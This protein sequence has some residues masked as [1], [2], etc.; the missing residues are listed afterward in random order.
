MDQK[1]QKIV[2]ATVSEKIIIFFDGYCI[3]C[4]K[5]VDFLISKD[6]K[7][8]FLFATLQSKTATNILNEIGFQEKQNKNLNTIVYFKNG[9]FKIKSNA[10]ID[11][12]SELGGVYQFTKIFYLIPLFLRD[13]I[14]DQIATKRYKWF[15]K[16]TTCR[17]LNPNKYT[18]IIN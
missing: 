3:L 10:V 14:Y 16:K 6:E 17:I 12:L 7:Q 9:T 5:T 15:G 4:N 1:I 11:I 18:R 13:L 8:K 2:A